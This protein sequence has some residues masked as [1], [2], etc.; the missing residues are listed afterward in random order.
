VSCLYW[1]EAV[2]AIPAWPRHRVTVPNYTQIYSLPWDAFPSSLKRD[3][4]AYIE[5]LTGSDLLAD[6]DFRPLRPSSLKSRAY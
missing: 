6:L 4:D 3:V 5:H 1:N 2:A